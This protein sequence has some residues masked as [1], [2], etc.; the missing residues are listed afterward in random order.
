MDTVAQLYVY[1]ILGDLSHNYFD[2][3]SH[4]LY[5][6]L[7]SGRVPHGQLRGVQLRHGHQHVR[8]P[9]GLQRAGKLPAQLRQLHTYLRLQPGERALS[10][11]LLLVVWLI[12]DRQGGS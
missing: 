6:R 9:H 10:A 7:V 4:V 12:I 11:P 5:R 1:L 3:V 8:V 2:D